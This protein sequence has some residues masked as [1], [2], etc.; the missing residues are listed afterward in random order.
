M[1]YDTGRPLL[2]RTRRV[3][4]GNLPI[5]RQR[6]AVVA[7]AAGSEGGPA[8]RLRPPT[9]GLR[10]GAAK[11]RFAR[12]GVRIFYNHAIYSPKM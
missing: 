2:V 7:V 5:D 12:S 9:D 10:P 3:F 11:G 1:V 6:G 8:D 4:E